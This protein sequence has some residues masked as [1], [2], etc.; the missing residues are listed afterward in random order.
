MS[1]ASADSP[2]EPEKARPEELALAK[3]EWIAVGGRG[4]WA[5]TSAAALTGALYE[6]KDTRKLTLSEV[7]AAVKRWNTGSE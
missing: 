7:K 3:A 6:Y 4:E 5:E 1:P 2:V